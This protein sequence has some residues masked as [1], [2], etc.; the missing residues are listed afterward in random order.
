[1]PL[2]PA[3]NPTY[4]GGRAC[5]ET[6]RAAAYEGSEDSLSYNKELQGPDRYAIPIQFVCLK[7]GFGAGAANLFSKV[8]KIVLSVE[9]G[10]A[11]EN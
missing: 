7:W 9:Q 6:G 1:M 10:L 8:A 4:H 3:P 11:R 2:T 5:T